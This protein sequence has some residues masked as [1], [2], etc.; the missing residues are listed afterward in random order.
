MR[1][2]DFDSDLTILD[3]IYIWTLWTIY[4]YVHTHNHYIRIYVCID[5]YPLDDSADNL[6]CVANPRFIHW[7]G[8]IKIEASM[9]KVA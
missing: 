8:R 1:T 7:H 9:G 6:S 5:H 2:Y 3:S 4:T